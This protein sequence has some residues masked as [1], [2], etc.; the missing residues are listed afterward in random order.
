MPREEVTEETLAFS[1][2]SLRRTPNASPWLRENPERAVRIGRETIEAVGG[3]VLRVF[4]LCCPQFLERTGTR[5][6]CAEAAE[7][8]GIAEPEVKR[9]FADGLA[10]ISK[11]WRLNADP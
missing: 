6:S 10:Q 5:Y 7:Q 4:E 11:A 3:Q 2:D 8:L 1:L 9:L